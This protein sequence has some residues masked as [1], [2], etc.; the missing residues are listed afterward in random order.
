MEKKWVEQEIRKYPSHLIG[1]GMCGY[2]DDILLF[3]TKVKT[4][5]ES[6]GWRDIRISSFYYC[7]NSV[8]YEIRGMRLETEGE[9]NKRIKEEEEQKEE[10]IEKEKQLLAKLKAKY[11]S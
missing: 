10:E 4:E 5:C 11:E 6:S 2:I 8:E 1:E 7:D 3:L 9:F